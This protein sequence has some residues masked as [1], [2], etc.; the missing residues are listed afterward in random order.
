M[1]EGFL[2]FVDDIGYDAVKS[3]YIYRFDFSTNIEEV[4]GTDFNI[5]PA[6]ISPV[7]QVDRNYISG[8]MNVF[9]DVKL[10][11][12]KKNTCFSM[13]DCI[14][15]IISLCFSD[16]EEPLRN[17]NKEYFKLDF[18]TPYSDVI[19]VLDDFQIEHDAIRH[20]VPNDDVILDKIINDLE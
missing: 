3:K 20:N 9:S 11:I 7:V 14:D 18:A 19:K 1:E 4:W 10:L 13:Q 15:G 5:T 17:K 12:A 8:Y 16:F 6:I 2:V